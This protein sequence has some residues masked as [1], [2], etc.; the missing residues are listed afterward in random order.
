LGR[1][2]NRVWKYVH[3]CVACLIVLLI[4][5][6]GI[7]EKIKILRE[8][9][10]ASEHLLRAKELLIKQDYEGS[11]EEN[12][13]VLSISENKPPA[14]EALFN[15]GLIYSHHGYQKRDYKKSLTFYKRLIKDF[16]ASPLVEQA[17][18]W[19][20]VLEVIEKIKQVDIEIEEKKKGFSR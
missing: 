18:I 9:K 1:K 14:D 12:Q 8:D 13:K 11:L 5:G 10:V 17:K 7:S 20:G 2:Q 16:P 3:F 19:I 4:I 15:M 6:C